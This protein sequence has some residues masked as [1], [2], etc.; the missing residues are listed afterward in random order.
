MPEEYIITMI[1]EMM[2][3]AEGFVHMNDIEKKQCVTDTMELL[4]GDEIYEKYSS[5]ISI[6]IDHTI[7]VSK[8]RYKIN[9]NKLCC[10]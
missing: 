1:T 7:K 8:G 5:F 9:S 6:I 10:F 3:Q 4:L 2:E